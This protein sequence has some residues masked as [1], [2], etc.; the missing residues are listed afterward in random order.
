MAFTFVHIVGLNVLKYISEAF[1]NTGQETNILNQ[2]FPREHGGPAVI[3]LR[4]R[5]LFYP[6][7][8]STQQ[9]RVLCSKSAFD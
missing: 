3:Y 1:G 8:L 9:S 7:F 6:L 4:S 2:S 5:P